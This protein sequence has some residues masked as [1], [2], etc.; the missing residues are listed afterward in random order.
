M[1]IFIAYSKEKSL[2]S[3]L[4][5]SSPVSTRFHVSRPPRA[6]TIVPA[7]ML[8]Q[9]MDLDGTNDPNGY[10]G[11]DLEKIGKGRTKDDRMD[12]DEESR[13]SRITRFQIAL[14]QDGYIPLVLRLVAFM[15]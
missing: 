15:F 7:E 12:S 14:L 3:R 2:T 6:Y 9:Q 8:N 11:Y 10:S 4:D 1:L 13:Y 5:P